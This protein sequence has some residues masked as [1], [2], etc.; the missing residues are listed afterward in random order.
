[1][2][3]MGSPLVSS[4]M[5][6]F[7]LQIACRHHK[8]ASS[9]SCRL[10]GVPASHAQP[11]IDLRYK[12]YRTLMPT[13]SLR[14]TCPVTA[15]DGRKIKYHFHNASNISIFP[16]TSSVP[17]TH[18]RVNRLFYFPLYLSAFVRPRVLVISR[19]KSSYAANGIPT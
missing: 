5:T 7:R 16:K 3:F 15:A 13:L 8:V 11:C 1:M 12:G 18:I 6:R 4:H 2:E 9:V 17:N 10:E 19:A 14:L